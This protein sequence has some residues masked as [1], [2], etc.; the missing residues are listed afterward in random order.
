MKKKLFFYILFLALTST[1]VQAAKF[2]FENSIDTINLLICNLKKIKISKICSIYHKLLN[3]LNKI[4]TNKDYDNV[5]IYMYHP[6]L[7]YQINSVE[8]E[9]KID[10]I[11]SDILF[12]LNELIYYYKNNTVYLYKALI[13]IMYKNCEIYANFEALMFDNMFYGIKYNKKT[14]LLPY[15]HIFYYLHLAKSGIYK[16]KIN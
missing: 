5:I 12:L 14:I 4:Q 9:Q 16:L 7:K 11:I 15:L 1:N 2:Y 3:E 13:N 6:T 10:I 8:I